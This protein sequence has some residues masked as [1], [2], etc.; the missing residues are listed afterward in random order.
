[1][2][3]YDIC[4]EH[5]RV[6]TNRHDVYIYIYIYIYDTENPKQVTRSR[7]EKTHVH[8]HLGMI[9]AEQ[10]DVGVLVKHGLGWRPVGPFEDLECLDA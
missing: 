6:I 5:T 7:I 4:K 8:A 9:F 10:G 3:T 1:V 2:Y